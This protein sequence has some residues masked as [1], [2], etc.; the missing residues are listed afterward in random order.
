[1]EDR[2]GGHLNAL[3]VFSLLPAL[4]EPPVDWVRPALGSSDM[5]LKLLHRP[6]RTDSGGRARLLLSSLL[7]AAQYLY[8]Y[9]SLVLLSPLMI[10]V[11]NE[12]STPVL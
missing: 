10:F 11:V 8:L 3:R 7:L 4:M 6:P 2:D 5:S 9:S 12:I 1:M